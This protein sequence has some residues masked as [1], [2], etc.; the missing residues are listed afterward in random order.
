MADADVDAAPPPEDAPVV[1]YVLALLAYVALGYALRS[2][3]LNWIVGPF[4][5]LV[6]L[7]LVPVAFC[8]WRSSR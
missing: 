5:L 7:H 6:V 1:A 2:V 8:R 4:F 3:V